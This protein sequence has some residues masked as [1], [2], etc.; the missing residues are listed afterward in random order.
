MAGGNQFQEDMK[1]AAKGPGGQSHKTSAPS[2]MGGGAYDRQVE[3]ESA[4]KDNSAI[5]GSNSAS[6]LADYINVSKSATQG[7]NNFSIDSA[8]KYVNNSRDQS[9]TNKADNAGF[10][11]QR[12][13]ENVNYANTQM[14]NNMKRNEGFAMGTTKNFMNNAKESREDNTAKATKFAD[15]TVDKYLNKNQ[16]WQAADIGQLD[17]T[18]RAAPINDRAYGTLQGKN[19][20]G[21]MYAYSRTELPEFKRGES[22][23]GTEMPDFQ[24]MYNQTKKDLDDYK[25]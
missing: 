23:K 12:R 18:V 9:K 10:S 24:G 5:Q 20:Y 3:R 1:K 22:M 16:Q 19:T 11:S 25:I 21:D 13:E 2:L 7:N 4:Q 17:K 8:N 14:D 15:Q 6:N